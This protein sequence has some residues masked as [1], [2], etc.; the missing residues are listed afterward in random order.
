MFGGLDDRGGVELSDAIGRLAVWFVGQ[1]FTSRLADGGC[2][3]ARGV[4]K[5]VPRCGGTD[6][7]ALVGHTWPS[8]AHGTEVESRSVLTGA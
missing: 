5:P 6:V 8:M 2:E 1:K 7:V 3:D 4:S